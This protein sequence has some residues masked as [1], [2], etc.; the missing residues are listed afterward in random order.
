MIRGDRQRDVECHPRPIPLAAA[1]TAGKQAIE[2]FTGSLAHE[3]ARF[4]IRVRLVEPGYASTARFAENTPVRIA[5]LIPETYA[6]FAAPIFAAW[7]DP[8]AVTTE[9]DVADAVWRAVNDTTD[10]L[11]HPAGAD[12]LALAGFA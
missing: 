1:Y 4:G 11:R 5:D 3:L 2:G 12:A 8:S 10:W 6:D 7:A 9:A